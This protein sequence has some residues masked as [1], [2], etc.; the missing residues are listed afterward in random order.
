MKD[1]FGCVTALERFIKNDEQE[2][3][4]ACLNAWSG[5]QAI[6][7]KAL[8]NSYLHKLLTFRHRVCSVVTKLQLRLYLLPT[9]STN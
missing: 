8:K 6:S 9:K 1:G 7:M 2:V 5:K 3:L 4:K